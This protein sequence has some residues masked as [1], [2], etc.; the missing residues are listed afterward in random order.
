MEGL[1]TT[2]EARRA[3]YEAYQRQ[4]NNYHQDPIV[5]KWV[6]TVGVVLRRH[7]FAT[8]LHFVAK[9][10]DFWI[11]EP[12]MVLQPETE[13]RLLQL[14]RQYCEHVLQTYPLVAAAF[15]TSLTPS[16]LPFTYALS[17]DADRHLR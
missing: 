11:E 9:S 12:R 4:C 16:V 1:A 7:G 8:V 6:E 17:T 15:T 3:E 5:E 2:Q 14:H 13:A 10:A